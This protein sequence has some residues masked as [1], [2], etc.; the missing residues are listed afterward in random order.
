MYKSSRNKPTRCEDE[1]PFEEAPSTPS[2]LIIAP[3][4]SPTVEEVDLVPPDLREKLPSESL[5][6]L[7]KLPDY[8]TKAVDE[9]LHCDS[10]VLGT[11][12][13]EVEEGK[14]DKSTDETGEQD[15]SMAG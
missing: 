4:S 7:P 8:D 2:T 3:P 13:L 11:E 6:A 5:E 9:D 15:A 14:D 1:K 12:P 10:E